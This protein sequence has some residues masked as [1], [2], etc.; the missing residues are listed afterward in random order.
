[1][2]DRCLVGGVEVGAELAFGLATLDDLG[3]DPVDS[4]A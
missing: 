3:D 2:Q 4:S 1:M